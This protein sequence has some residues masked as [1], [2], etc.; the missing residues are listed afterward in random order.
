MFFDLQLIDDELEGDFGL[1]EKWKQYV[2][3]H[4]EW[5]YNAS[6]SDEDGLAK[7]QGAE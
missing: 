1:T 2:R 6:L 7:R 4:H 3:R 5:K